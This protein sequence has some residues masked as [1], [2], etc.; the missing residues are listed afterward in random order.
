[1]KTIRPVLFLSSLASLV[2][3]DPFK[4]GINAGIQKQQESDALGADKLYYSTSGGVPSV[5]STAVDDT[6]SNHLSQCIQPLCCGASRA[7]W[8]P[9]AAGFPFG[10]FLSL[11]LAHL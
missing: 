1:M 8:A 5:H 6:I 10:L 7:E 11:W 2:A 3:A 9:S 4:F